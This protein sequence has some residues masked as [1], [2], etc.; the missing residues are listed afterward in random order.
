MRFVGYIICCMCFLVWGLGTKQNSAGASGGGGRKAWPPWEIFA[1]PPTRIHKVVMDC[2]KYWKGYKFVLSVARPRAKKL[3]ASGG[4]AP[5]PPWPGALPLDP[6]GG[7]APDSRYRLAL[8]ALAMCPKTAHLPLCSSTL[9]ASADNDCDWLWLIV[10]QNHEITE[11]VI[12]WFSPF[13][14]VF[15]KCRDFADCTK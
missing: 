7:S 14:V 6:A 3:S 4:F 10:I 5:L 11:A 1:P 12:S 8:H 2:W 15:T 13:A 9:N